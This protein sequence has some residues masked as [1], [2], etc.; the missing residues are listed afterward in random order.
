MKGY[1]PS[2]SISFSKKSCLILFLSKPL[3]L[4]SENRGF[5]LLATG[6]MAYLATCNDC[7]AGFFIWFS[8]VTTFM[9][10][11]SLFVFRSATFITTPGLVLLYSVIQAFKIGWVKFA[12]FIYNVFSVFWAIIDPVTKKR[13]A[14]N[15]CEFDISWSFHMISY[16]ILNIVY[17]I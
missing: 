1:L 2:S 14:I 9:S 3:L 10:I 8:F 12:P 11:A 16:Y 6:N 13:A 5:C 7:W 4:I 17:W 15:K